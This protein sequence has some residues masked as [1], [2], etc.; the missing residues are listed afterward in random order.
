MVIGTTTLTLA[1]GTK[2]D[3]VIGA[4]LPSWS[5]EEIMIGTK[6][7]DRV[8]GSA[9]ASELLPVTTS[10]V[11]AAGVLTTVLPSVLVLVTGDGVEASLVEEATIDD[12]TVLPASLVEVTGTV[13]A[14]PLLESMEEVKVCSLEVDSAPEEMEGESDEPVTEVSKVE[15]VVRPREETVVVSS[16][17]L[18]G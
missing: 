2:A 14:S 5:V 11:I 17:V 13:V 4:T 10:L 12:T 3:V 1:E 6:T 7:P 16:E 8:V 18:V 9:E 15:A